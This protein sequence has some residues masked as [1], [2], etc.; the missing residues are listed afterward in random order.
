MLVENA[1]KLAFFCKLFTLFEWGHFVKNQAH[2]AP[3]KVLFFSA[4]P[5]RVEGV[6]PS[7]TLLQPILAVEVP[8][9]N[10]QIPA[11]VIASTRPRLL[12]R[13]GIQRAWR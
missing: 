3:L 11:R 4:P 7:P 12:S 2:G 9:W 10:L 1:N 8:S 6:P 13:G 5:A